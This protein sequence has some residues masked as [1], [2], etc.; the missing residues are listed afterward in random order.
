M[1]LDESK[2]NTPNAGGTLA[3]HTYDNK[4]Y[5][6]TVTTKPATADYAVTDKLGN[7]AG[8][9]GVISTSAAATAA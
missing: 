9:F 5:L 6:G 7:E 4:F 2:C 3:D 8:V 1:H